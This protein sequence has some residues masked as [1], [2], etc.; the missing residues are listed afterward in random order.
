MR[1]WL[2]G[3]PWKTA[4]LVL[5]A[6]LGVALL[7]PDVWQPVCDAVNGLVPAAAA[8]PVPI[9]S[10]S[11]SPSA[12]PAPPKKPED[13][14]AERARKALGKAQETLRKVPKDP[15]G[16]RDKALELINTAITESTAL[17]PCSL[18]TPATTGA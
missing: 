4:S 7:A 6:A 18:A 11:S 14:A 2:V 3:D 15:D 8:Q 9:L 1:A 13:R 5:T 16:H 17:A 12:A 10:P